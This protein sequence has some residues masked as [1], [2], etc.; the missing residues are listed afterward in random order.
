MK[1]IRL[2]P[3]QVEARDAVLAQL[4]T[5]RSTLIVLPTGC[6][7]TITFAALAELAC[8]RGRVLVLA[9]RE[10][11]VEQARDKIA[12]F[13]DL[14]CGVE[15]GE[16]TCA[17]VEMPQVVS[18]SVQT[19]SRETRRRAYAPDAFCF[20]IVDEA[21]HAPA[22][23]YRSILSYFARAKVLGVTA[24]P[25]RM[26]GQGMSE[27]FES[28]AYVYEIRD[29]IEGGFLVP[30]RQRTVMIQGLDL[31][32][33]ASRAGDFAEGELERAL[34]DEDVLHKMAVPTI[35]L[36]GERPT[37][38]FTAGVD[39]AHALAGVMN[40][41]KPGLAAAVDGTTD[42]AL[43]RK[44]IE[45]F[46]SG[47][48]QYL[49]NCAIF[50]EGFDAPPTSCVSVARPTQSRALYSQMVGR[51]TRTSPATGKR[52]LLVLDLVGQAGKHSLVNCTDILDGNRDGEVRQLAMR[53]LAADPEMPVLEA[54]DEAE[55]RIA[56]EKR[57]RV[58][59]AVRYT[60]RDVD[61]FN[62]LGASDR[63]GRWGGIAPTEKQLEIL[64]NAGLEPKKIKGLDKGQ[65]SALITKLFQRRQDGLCTFKQAQRLARYGLNPD[66]P[67]EDA[68][69]AM[70]AIAQ[71]GWKRAPEELYWDPVLRPKAKVG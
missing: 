71:N 47:R 13:A 42:R 69:R 23:T 44:L 31:S 28:V 39:H 41:Y 62:V 8:R 59:A 10:E 30:I 19:L 70:D 14:T 26:D 9:H 61:P 48:I 18:A 3:Y 21:H 55:E 54:L 49:L 25:D 57:A 12:R 34:M 53:I 40:R 66:V 17:G 7:K 1:G 38:V 63:A 45:D 68:R 20:V 24:T 29:A 11:L 22:D 52:D 5:C 60:V 4:R 64:E 37:I 36:S 58:V 27:V 51:G 46:S 6:G 56:A 67:F 50:T 33:I 35:E 16:R 15:M 65:A 32:R 43:R 2:H